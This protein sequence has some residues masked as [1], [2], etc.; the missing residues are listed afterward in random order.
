MSSSVQLCAGVLALACLLVVGCTGG[1]ADTALLADQQTN[2]DR[3]PPAAAVEVNVLN[4]SE[5][6]ARVQIHLYIGNTLVHH[7]EALLEPL[8][9][10]DLASRLV[11]DLEEADRVVIT[12]RI[13]GPEGAALWS[14]QRTY[15]MGADFADLDTVTYAIVY[16]PAP[17]YQAPVAVAVAPTSVAADS[18]V[19]LDGSASTG[20][21]PLTYQWTQTGGP[22]VFLAYNADHS[23]ATFYAPS[24]GGLMSFELTVSDGTHSDTASVSVY[25]APLGPVNNPPVAFATGPSSAVVGD[26]VVLDGVGSTD[27]DGDSLTYHWTQT[28]SLSDPAVTL[29]PAANAWQIRFAV[30]DTVTAPQTLTFQLVVNDGVADSDPA[31]VSVD[32]S[33]APPTVRAR[34]SAPFFG[35]ADYG[36]TLNGSGSTGPITSW[37]WAQVSGPYVWL[38][39][40][41]D[42]AVVGFTVPSTGGWMTFE[43]TVSDGTNSDTAT[44]SVYGMSLGV[45]GPPPVV[46][47]L[48]PSIALA[49]DTVALRGSGSFDPEGGP[50]S[51]WWRQTNGPAVTLSSTTLPDITFT[52]P[53]VLAETVLV[54]EL[55]VINDNG[56]AASS[57]IPIFIE[58]IGYAGNHA[59]RLTATADVA[60]VYEGWEVNL[61]AS[62]SDVPDG[63]TPTIDWGQV[64]GADVTATWTTTADSEPGYAFEGH[65]F[66]APTG[67]D[68][69]THVLKFIVV[70]E[71]G[72]AMPGVDAVPVTVTVRLTGDVD[73]DGTVTSA[74]EAL[75]QDIIGSKPGDPDWNPWA[76]LDRTGQITSSDQDL[77]ISNMG[78]TLTPW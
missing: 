14:D 71:D 74:D 30:P 44:I 13:D 4:N 59:P 25:G 69:M 45:S 15:R 50:L 78:R 7:C 34:P 67:V 66:A 61:A 22:S 52:A 49:G 75:V 51:F 2:P 56:M 6:P 48:G 21:G 26:V 23:I 32:V 20:T 31:T 40:D 37:H 35:M 57:S 38:S 18:L 41:P 63:D 36:V 8:S 70:A 19:I 39:P 68:E 62:A 47:P 29:V 11:L 16:P 17:D 72:N 60:E 55:M 28:G 5:Y 73:G 65:A 46:I 33:P 64:F 9:G 27:P 42:Q 24:T 54:F 43:L 53:D 10:S 76:D 3:D 58:P 77:V 12:C 1:P